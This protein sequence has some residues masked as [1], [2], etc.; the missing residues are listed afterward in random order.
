MALEETGE[1]RDQKV[2]DT[3]TP[4]LRNQKTVINNTESRLKSFILRRFRDIDVMHP[5]AQDV[6]RLKNSRALSTK[7]VDQRVL[8]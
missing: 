6:N 1:P 7:A 3:E 5:L 4:K 8:Q 2:E